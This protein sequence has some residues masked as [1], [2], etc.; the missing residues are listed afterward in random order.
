MRFFQK[1]LSCQAFQES[2]P[3]KL[4]PSCPFLHLPT[5]TSV[6]PPHTSA[7][8]SIPSRRILCF[9]PGIASASVNRQNMFLKKLS[10]TVRLMVVKVQ[11]CCY[12]RY[13]RTLVLTSWL[14]KERCAR[15]SQ[16][17]VSA[18]R[19]QTTKHQQGWKESLK[20][21]AVPGTG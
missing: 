12:S 21:L 9:C 3:K 17:G 15:S 20:T 10:C 8:S 14:A 11:C 7:N 4:P 13:G 6:D 5:N 19:S 2:E 1:S 18:L 16:R